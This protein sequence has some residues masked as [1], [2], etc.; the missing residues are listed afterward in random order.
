MSLKKK[1]ARARTGRR[2][3]SRMGRRGS[4]LRMSVLLL[5]LRPNSRGPFSPSS[6]IVSSPGNILTVADGLSK[7]DGQKLLEM[8][9]HLA[10]RVNGTRGRGKA[11]CWIG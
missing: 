7:N 10:K 3:R 9:E 6:L 1:K 2:V 8:M 5:I 11:G 4:H